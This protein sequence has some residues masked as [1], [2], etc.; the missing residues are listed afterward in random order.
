MNAT[1]EST[2]GFLNS[3]I[4]ISVSKLCYYENCHFII[5]VECNWSPVI[6]K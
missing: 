3:F 4:W 6:N 1:H 5:I 2:V